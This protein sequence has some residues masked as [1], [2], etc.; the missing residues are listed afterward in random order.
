MAKRTLVIVLS[1]VIVVFGALGMAAGWHYI[2]I[3][4]EQDIRTIRLEKEPDFVF[5]ADV[6]NDLFVKI[7]SELR[8]YG[9]GTGYTSEYIENDIIKAGEYGTPYA[10]DMDHY[11]WHN[12]RKLWFI[13]TN[14]DLYVYDTVRDTQKLKMEGVAD[15]YCDSKEYFAVLCDGTVKV[16]GEYA[17][18]YLG[19]PDEEPVLEPCT[20]EGVSDIISIARGN[21][22]IL[23]LDKNGNVYQ[24]RHIRDYVY[25]PFEIVE[26]LSGITEIYS[27]YG[28]GAVSES[29]EVYYWFDSPSSD[30]VVPDVDKTEDITRRLNELG[31]NHISV[32]PKYSIG[33]NDKEEVYK[34]GY[35]GPSKTSKDEIYYR[36]PT[37]LRTIDRFDD[38]YTGYMD[39]YVKDGLNIR[40]IA[41]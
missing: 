11:T 16:W 32:M 4:K 27:G 7:G 12:Q 18:R 21:Q 39:I 33:Y 23:L 36:T 1:A 26:G 35:V 40:R 28:N 25:T 20:L 37:K 41:K 8:I 14:N 38:I 5:T 24:S 17:Y 29:G 15:F 19:T 31:V 34:W 22:D 30:V 9:E 6:C 2:S 10:R 13:D 3:L